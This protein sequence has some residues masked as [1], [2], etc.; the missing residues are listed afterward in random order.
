MDIV[1]LSV[2]GTLAYRDL[3]LRVVASVCRLV[4]RAAELEQE[5][6]HGKRAEDFDDRVVSA[7]GEGFNNI[8]IHAYR[9]RRGAAEIELEFDGHGLTIRLVDTGE[10]FEIS[11]AMRSNLEPLRESKMGLEIMRASMDLVTYTRGGPTSPNVLTMTKSCFVK[12]EGS[13]RTG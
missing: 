11:E 12:A 13:T 5:P 10:G 7:V 3:V 8:A 1:R 2:P 4:R 9:N 6:G